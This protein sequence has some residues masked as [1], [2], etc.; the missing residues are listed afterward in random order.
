MTGFLVLGIIISLFRQ[1]INQTIFSLTQLA[2]LR[3]L[4]NKFYIR[5]KY[6]KN[7]F[8]FRKESLRISPFD[9]QFHSSLNKVS[10]KGCI[11]DISENKEDGI[12]ADTFTLK[13]AEIPK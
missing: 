2:E 10:G 9:L 4:G 13:I 3:Q 6:N 1:A 11:V 12:R 7:K 8:F 5:L